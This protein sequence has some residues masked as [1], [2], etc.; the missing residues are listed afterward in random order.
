M[1]LQ[2]VLIAVLLIAL[3]F[4]AGTHAMAGASGEAGTQRERERDRAPQNARRASKF[5]ELTK[6]VMKLS[7]IKDN[8]SVVC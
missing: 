7:V 2:I 6:I 8:R 1:W 4:V 3:C 5:V